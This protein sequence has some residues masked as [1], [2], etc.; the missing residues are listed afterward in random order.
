MRPKARGP[1]TLHRGYDDLAEK[2]ELSATCAS[3][4]VG[5]RKG[6]R[7][8]RSRHCG[9]HAGLRQPYQGRCADHADGHKAYLEAVEDAFGADIDY[10][11]LQKIYGARAANDTRYSPATRIG[12]EMKTVK[13]KSRS[14]TCQH[15]LC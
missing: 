11:Q 6:R 3:C 8:S 12:C 4:L 9:V 15:E 10:A 14:E 13:W 5:T 1:R 2:Y 7:P